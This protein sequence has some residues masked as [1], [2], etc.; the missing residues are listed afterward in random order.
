VQGGA[1]GD[2]LCVINNGDRNDGASS[3]HGF[4][5]M[6]DLGGLPTAAKKFAEEMPD[7]VRRAFLGVRARFHG[8]VALRQ[9]HARLAVCVNL[10]SASG[11]AHLRQMFLR[12]IGLFK[13][14]EY[15]YNDL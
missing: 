14:I 13:R 2:H 15:S 8:A 3:T 11:N 6:A 10:H 12:L 4:L 9:S 5:I 1:H 7:L